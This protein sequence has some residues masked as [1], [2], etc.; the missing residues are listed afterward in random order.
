MPLTVKS[1]KLVVDGT[2]TMHDYSLSTGK[3]AISAVVA[4]GA[5][6]L[7]PAILKAFE[8]QIPVNS[9]VSE[10]D[11]LIKKFLETMKADKHPTIAFRLDRLYGRR[12]GRSRQRGRS[13]LPG[14]LA[15]SISK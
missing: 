7:Q 9:F 13:R 4:D 3:L 5:S 10:K 12:R 1:A 11:G 15:R 8:L 2:S 14:S 6:L